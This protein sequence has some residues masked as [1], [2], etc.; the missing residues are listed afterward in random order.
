MATECARATALGKIMNRLK[1]FVSLTLLGGMA[2]VLPVAIMAILFQWLFR[3][4]TTFIQPMTDWLTSRAEIQEIMADGVVVLIIVATCFLIGLL[5][6]TGVGRWLHH[7]LDRILG[8]LAPGYKTIR[9]I[10]TQF[11]G[12]DSNES[13]LNG[14]VCKARVFGE[15]SPATMTAIVTAT[16]IDGSYSVFVPTAPIPT[17]G[18]VYHLPARCVE[19]LPHLTVEA[20]MRTVIACGAGSQVLRVPE[21]GL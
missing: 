10:V 17:S 13:L 15:N 21:P 19:L 16:H 12:G 6:K 1:A 18:M 2:V 8:R 3:L 9:E 14:Q 5:I 7:W 4:V 11:L 20:A